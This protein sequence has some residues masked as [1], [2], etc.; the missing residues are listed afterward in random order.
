MK[1][2]QLAVTVI[3]LILLL[4][5]APL[6][7]QESSEEENKQSGPGLDFGMGLGIGAETFNENI[8]GVSTPITWQTFSFSPEL[9]FGKF[10]IGLD[11]TFHFRFTGG[12][13]NDTFEFRSEDWVPNTAADFLPLYL[14]KF[15]YIRWAHKGDPLYIK[16]GSIEDGLLGNGFIMGN[17]AN[18]MFLPE[19]RLF[20]LSFDMD[21]E[22]FQFPYIGIETFVA[23]LA[24]FDVFGTR[25]YTR[26]LAWMEA[27][28]PQNLQV[29][30]TVAVDRD[31]YYHL[32]NR[33]FNGDGTDDEGLVYILGGDIKV[34]I[35]AK[36]LISFVT[37]GDIAFEK[38][39]AGGMLG[40]GGRL[41]K[42]VPYRAELRILG[43]NFIPVYFDAVYDLFRPLKYEIFAG[44]GEIPGYVGWLGSTGISLFDDA[45]SFIIA[46]DGPFKKPAPADSSNFSNYPH[47]RADFQ[48]TQDLLPGIFMGASYDKRFLREFNDLIDP[49]GAVIGAELGFATGPAS[50]SLVY[51]LRYDP[52]LEGDE[53]W[54]ITSGLQSSLSLF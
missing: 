7:S 20:G 2:I 43:K 41:L 39:H 23:N 12:E 28:I 54:E 9:T 42:V 15:Q 40:F 6:W 5:A 46:V 36:P 10:G 31:P 16:L 50:I 13:L 11:V 1:R 19:K 32:E 30:F 24:A 47:L 52:S 21:G 37:F 18:T 29:G 25:L 26:P 48:L 22:L 49:E 14:P 17:Y 45:L 3:L 27:S 8:D 51:S 44:R 53:K 33:D 38:K 35:L 34:P 4:S